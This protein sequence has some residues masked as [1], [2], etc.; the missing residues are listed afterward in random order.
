LAVSEVTK[1]VASGIWQV[2]CISGKTRHEAGVNA[3]NVTWR[4]NALTKEN[5]I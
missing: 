3:G 2:L 5:E 1:P 4:I